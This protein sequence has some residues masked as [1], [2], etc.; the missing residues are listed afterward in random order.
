MIIN[1]TGYIRPDAKSTNLLDKFDKKSGRHDFANHFEQQY[2]FKIAV[3]SFSRFDMIAIRK[4]F[5]MIL[6]YT[7]SC[8]PGFLTIKN[9]LKLFMINLKYKQSKFKS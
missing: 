5:D 8:R 3:N 9:R 6:L 7:K 4:Y 2:I 1:N